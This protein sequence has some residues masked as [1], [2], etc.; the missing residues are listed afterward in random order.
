MR[1]LFCS[2][3][4]HQ[5][6]A[7]GFDLEAE[8]LED[9][10][11]EPLW[12]PIEAVVEDQLDEAL[13]RFPTSG[14]QTILRSWMLTA[15][16]YDLLFDALADHG[17]DL[18][19][20][21]A[22]Y[23]AAHYLPGYYPAIEEWSAPTRWIEGTDLDEAWIAARE[24]GPPPYLIKDHVKSAKENWA[25][26]YVPAG[27]DRERFDEVCTAFIDHRG[28]LFE[29]G[30]AFRVQL[31]LAPL[32]GGAPGQAIFDE[33]RLWFCDGELVTATPYYDVDGGLTDFSQLAGL[34]DRIGSYFFTVDVARLVDG[35]LAVI[36]VGDGGVSRLPPRLHP[37]EL[38]RAVF[39][40]LEGG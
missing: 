33:Y 19:N 20:D 14:G 13:G 39:E 26:C 40:Q 17:Y 1:V 12:I 5:D 32:A 23:A 28:E 11:V 7:D 25:A 15:D 29:R 38:Y 8:A 36:E 6:R 34:G 35:S 18:I 9:L 27:A 31:A 10:G 37:R 16:D 4:S 21:S 24:L 2:P 30:L 22:A 3:R